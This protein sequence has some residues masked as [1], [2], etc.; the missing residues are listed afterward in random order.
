MPAEYLLI[1]GKDK[2]LGRLASQVAK[3]ALLGKNVVVVNAEQVVISGDK[4][5]IFND[6]Q[7][8]KHKK[9][10]TNPREGPFFYK[11]PDMRFRRTVR[12]ML[13]WKYP[14]G[15][16]AFHKVHV[17]IGNEIDTAAQFPGI[18]PYEVVGANADRLKGSYITLKDLGDRFGWHRKDK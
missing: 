11:R 4:Q 3:L 5:M 10:R 14:R 18:K 16:E 1:D 13:P 6:Y 9:V 7:T 12:S 2:I 15:R 17:F 8:L